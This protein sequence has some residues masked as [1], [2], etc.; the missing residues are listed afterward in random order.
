M[1]QKP[2]LSARSA[3]GAEHLNAREIGVQNCHL[4][5]EDFLVQRLYSMDIDQLRGDVLKALGGIPLR[6]EQ[7]FTGAA[8]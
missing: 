2:K 5:I 7:L 1:A 6:R 4:R 8:R 3:L